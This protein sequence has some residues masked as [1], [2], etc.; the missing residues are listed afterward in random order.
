VSG[1]Q[2]PGLAG[3][4]VV[5]TRSAHQA[6][7]LGTLLQDAGAHPIYM[8]AIAIEDPDSF[9]ELDRALDE[10]ARGEFSW[11]VFASVNAITKLLERMRA[12]SMNA[13]AL[14]EARVAAVGSSSAAL[15]ERL[16]VAV[17]LVPEIFTSEALAGALGRGPGRVLLPRVADAPADLAEMLK[18][19]GWEPVERV[20]YR[21]VPGPRD[22]HAVRA[23]K[24]GRFDVVTFASPSAVRGFVDIAGTASEL[25]L[26]QAARTGAVVACIGPTTADAAR[27]LGFRV[28]LVPDEHTSRGLVDALRTHFR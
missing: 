24:A 12:R 10:L 23:V 18:S 3:A 11:V 19:L 14:K 22:A 28:D 4:R 17:D 27:S 21:N 15:L 20:A 5:V 9:D 1:A 26:T 6:A 25:G 16:G 8:P 2:G 7:G 13:G